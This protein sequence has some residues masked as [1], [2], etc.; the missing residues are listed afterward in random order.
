[1]N[2]NGDRICLNCMHWQEDSLKI[3]S[4][5][6]VCRLANK[7]S[8]PNDTCPQFAPKST[9]DSLQDPNKYNDDKDR[10]FY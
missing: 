7:C 9:F 6:S 3:S 4:D 1:M 2:I 5:A 8:Q 10:L